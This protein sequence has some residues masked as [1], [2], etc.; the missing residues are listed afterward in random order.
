MLPPTTPLLVFLLALAST[1]LAQTRKDLAGIVDWHKPQIGIP[2]TR[3]LG[4]APAFHPVASPSEDSI[5]TLTKSN[6]LASL[7]PIDGSIG[8]DTS[9]KRQLRG[10]KEML[11]SFLRLASYRISLET[12]A[13]SIGPRPKL[14]SYRQHL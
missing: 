11:T 10:G 3:Q 6:V 12:S 14:S 4:G 9:S 1:T 7:S 13:P 5:F 2:L 8:K